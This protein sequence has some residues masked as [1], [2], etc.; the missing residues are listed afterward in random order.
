MLRIKAKQIK[1]HPNLDSSSNGLY[2]S[3]KN[4]R[5][6]SLCEHVALN[7]RNPLSAITA[8]FQ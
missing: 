8:D 6:Y 1:K 2:Y 3:I 4:P 5:G 7:K